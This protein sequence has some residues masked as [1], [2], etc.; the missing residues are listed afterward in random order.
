MSFDASEY[1][2][3]L[4]VNRSEE[5]NKAYAVKKPS[6]PYLKLSQLA[7]GDY[8]LRFGPS[9]PGP[10]ACPDGFLR[11]CTHDVSMDLGEKTH[12]RLKCILAHK[13]EHVPCRPCEIL[14]QL[15][16]VKSQLPKLV[17]EALVEMNPDRFRCVAFPV[18][19]NAEPA[20]DD[21]KGPWKHSNE[22]NGGFLQV[23]AES[24]LR[25]IGDAY[26]DIPFLNH[27]TKGR[28]LRLRKINGGKGMGGYSLKNPEGSKP[29]PIRNQDLLEKYRMTKMFNAFYKTTNNFTYTQQVDFLKKAWWMK[30]PI[31]QKTLGGYDENPYEDPSTF[32]A[33]AASAKTTAYSDDW[34]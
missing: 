14:D 20:T 4:N 30:D 29:C 25:E 10:E 6:F 27:E 23:Y 12:P 34:E 22:E 21:P 31:V 5:Y 8:D 16:P 24:M 32:E 11:V 33:P 15:A 2:D 1:D 28:Y 26:K 17:Q 9:I 7:D 18:F 19:L 13:P 3:F